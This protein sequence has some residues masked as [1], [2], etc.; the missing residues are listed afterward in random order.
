MEERIAI[1]KN[2]KKLTA[3]VFWG[4]IGIFFIILGQ[5]FIPALE[6]VFKGPTLSLAPM[7][8]FCLLG[9]ALLVLSLREKVEKKFQGF[10]ILTGASATGFFAFVILHNAFYALG[11]IIGQ[12]FFL[13]YLIESLQIA[14]FLIAIFVCPIAFLVGVIGSIV[15]RRNL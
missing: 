11:L 14:S 2:L 6:N 4:L 10:L 12:V 7:I 13:S 3:T 15:Y 9:L 5:F 8:V 1:M